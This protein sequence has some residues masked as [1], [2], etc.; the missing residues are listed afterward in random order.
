ML[1]YAAAASVKPLPDFAVASAD[2]QGLDCS[3]LN[4]TVESDCVEN[5]LCDTAFSGNW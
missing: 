2:F 4:A 3:A 5:A 1:A